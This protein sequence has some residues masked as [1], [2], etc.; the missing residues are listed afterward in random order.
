MI[1]GFL[2]ITFCDRI[3][4][5]SAVRHR[6]V[7]N[8]EIGEIIAG[9]LQSGIFEARAVT[10]TRKIARVARCL[11]GDCRE[12][13]AV[14]VSE[15]KGH[16]DTGTQHVPS[17]PDSPGYCSRDVPIARCGH[18]GCCVAAA[19]HIMSVVNLTRCVGRQLINARRVIPFVRSSLSL[20][21]IYFYHICEIIPYNLTKGQI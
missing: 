21:Y 6:Y 9:K 16:V 20:S 1:L 13:I 4:L 19:S 18:P 11:I 14:K 10:S 15:K 17:Q 8:A 2:T 3:A 12:T 7:R 5:S